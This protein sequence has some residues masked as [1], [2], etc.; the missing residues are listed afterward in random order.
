MRPLR[1]SEVQNSQ[2]FNWIFEK[3][4]SE[5]NGF[6]FLSEKKR[7]ISGSNIMWISLQ[8]LHLH[9]TETEGRIELRF[10]AFERGGF[11]LSEILKIAKIIFSTQLQK[12][13]C[14][15]ETKTSK[16]GSF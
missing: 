12:N 10:V 4:S 5:K 1:A 8:V 3:Q 16:V 2:R 6:K 13:H 9:R 7:Q 11:P 14:I 15:S